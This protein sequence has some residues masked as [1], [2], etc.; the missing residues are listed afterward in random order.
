LN[1][2]FNPESVNQAWA[3]DVTYLRTAEGWCYLAVVT[4]LHSRRV[5][6]WRI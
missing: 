6:G 5:I 2:R 1:Q 4:D 3:G